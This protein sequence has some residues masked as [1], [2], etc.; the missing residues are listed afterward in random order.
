MKLFLSFIL[1]LAF[2][3][4]SENVSSQKSK[5]L[6]ITY[7]KDYRSKLDTTKA[8]SYKKEM[9]KLNSLIAK[10]SKEVSYQLIIAEQHSLFGQNE[11]KMDK[12]DYGRL[13]ELAGS[14]GGTKGKFYVNK[15]KDTY[16]NK[17][18]FW[19]EDFLIKIEVKK[20]KITNEFKLISDFKCYKA[21]S[22]DIV[23]NH[24]GIFKSK[25]VAWFCPELPSFF[26]PAGYFGL[27]GLILELDNGKMNLRATK[28]HF[29]KSKKENI[30]PFKK[31]IILTEKE[32]DKL[33]EKKAKAI[34][35][36]SFKNKK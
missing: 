12:S 13:K 9:S 35:P 15:K 29:S 22:E 28:I 24:K 19:G 5:F 32:F 34:F 21:I 10:Y 23:T 3:S 4:K 25:V 1:L 33:M 7:V 6:K 36:K 26:G 27:P 20:W 8:K 16:L 14:I 30:K 17:I 11:S 2:I 31:G 18:H